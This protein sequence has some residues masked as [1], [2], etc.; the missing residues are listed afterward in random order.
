MDWRRI[1]RG[2]AAKYI[3]VGNRELLWSAFCSGGIHCFF[4]C[5]IDS[6]I[7]GQNPHCKSGRALRKYGDFGIHIRVPGQCVSGTQWYRAFFAKAVP[8][9]WTPLGGVGTTVFG[10]LW[11]IFR[12]VCGMPCTSHRGD[13]GQHPHLCQEDILPAGIALGDFIHGPGQTCGI[14]PIL[15]HG[16]PP[17]RRIKYRSP[18]PG[19][20]PQV[21]TILPQPPP[22]A[23]AAQCRYAGIF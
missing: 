12:Y 23:L 6:A 3:Y 10:S 15:L 7:C 14:P 17:H 9:L 2:N 16:I 18:L 4:C 11:F 20:A 5:R 1:I 21:V 19:M 13:A 8:L 22:I